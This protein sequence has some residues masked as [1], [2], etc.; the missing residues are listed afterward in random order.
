MYLL[1]LCTTPSFFVLS[2]SVHRVS[3]WSVSFPKEQSHPKTPNFS[4]LPLEMAPWDMKKNSDNP[5]YMP[6]PVPVTQYSYFRLYAEP[7]QADTPPGCR[8]SP[9]PCPPLRGG[10]S[11]PASA[12]W[13]SV[14]SPPELGQ[15]QEKTMSMISTYVCGS[16]VLQLLLTTLPVHHQ[17]PTSGRP[18]S[19]LPAPPTPLRERS[20]STA[21]PHAHGTDL[22]RG[23]RS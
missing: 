4:I 13:H 15:P 20:G 12:P 10:R 8:A 11:A 16:W 1:L 17:H 7:P 9:E 5:P 14:V 3:V 21:A 22:A 23:Y 2:H 19:P 6:K 18:P